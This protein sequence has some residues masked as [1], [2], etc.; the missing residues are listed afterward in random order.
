MTRGGL[1]LGLGFV[2]TP[3]NVLDAYAVI[4]EEA[5]RLSLSLHF[6]RLGLGDGMPR[7]GGDPVSA[8]AACG[9]T[10][11][12]GELAELCYDDVNKLLESADKLAKTAREYGKSDE[13]IS[14]VFN[15]AEYR[16]EPSPAPPSAGGMPR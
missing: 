14:A 5:T 15:R 4:A 7:C 16:Y 8:D 3:E 1:D 2:V 9:F 13:Q 10:Q 11:V 6:F 12:A